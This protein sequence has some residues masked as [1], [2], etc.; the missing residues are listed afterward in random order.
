M[1][2]LRFSRNVRSVVQLTRTPSGELDADV[3]YE[4][5]RKKPKKS[6]AFLRP[7]D[8]FARRFGEAQEAS[9]S[10]YLERHARSNEKR[11]NGWFADLPINLARS[12]RAGQKA[13]KLRRLFL[14]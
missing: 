9:A 7:L 11:R 8:R 2:D 5:A 3:I 13:L 1:T 10:K 14:A 12:N 6:S 4:R